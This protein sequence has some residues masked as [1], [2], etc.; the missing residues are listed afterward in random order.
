M[1]IDDR[2]ATVAPTVRQKLRFCRP[3]IFDVIPPNKAKE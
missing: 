3:L 2:R 1:S